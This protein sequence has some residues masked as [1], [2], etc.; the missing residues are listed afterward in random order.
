MTP[1]Q[2]IKAH[3]GVNLPPQPADGCIRWFAIDEL[4]NGFIIDLGSCAV[5]GSVIDGETI[6]FDGVNFWNERLTHKDSKKIRH[7]WMVW[8]MA[9]SAFERGER[10]SEEDNQR[11][12]LAV[13]RLE[14]WL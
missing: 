2:A 4:R 1:R 10:L 9:R 3:Y 8:E 12:A 13:K 14:A 5:F 7:E 11:L 6:S